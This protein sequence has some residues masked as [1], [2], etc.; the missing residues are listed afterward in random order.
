MSYAKSVLQPNEHI[1]VMGRL[2][3]IIYWR[4]IACLVFGTVLLLL[5]QIYGVDQTIKVLTAALVFV[6]G[7]VVGLTAFAVMPSFARA[8]AKDRVM[9]MIAALVTE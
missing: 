3:W 2:H 5:E 8:S 4:A 1:I 9:L 7:V 6:A